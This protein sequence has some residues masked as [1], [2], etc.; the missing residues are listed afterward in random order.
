[1]LLCTVAIQLAGSAEAGASLNIMFSSVYAMQIIIVTQVL[2]YRRFHRNLPLTEDVAASGPDRPLVKH[3]ASQDNKPASAN[4]LS[5]D[6]QGDHALAQQIRVILEQQDMY[7]QANLKV[8]DLARKMDV[9]EYRISRVFRDHFNARNFNQFINEMR[10]G[11]AKTLLEDPANAHWPI[12][13]VGMESG[14]ASV[15]PFTRAFKSSCEMTPN[16]YRETYL[17]RSKNRTPSLVG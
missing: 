5:N 7:L 9:S 8:A 15:G 16:Q 17:A 12:I 1:V 4:L 3:A 13:V 11:H 6:N 10:I 2:I 14:F